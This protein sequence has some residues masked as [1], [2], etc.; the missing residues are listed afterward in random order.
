MRHI[1]AKRNDF[2][3]IPRQRAISKISGGSGNQL[4]SKSAMKSRA[5]QP[6]RLSL[7]DNTQLYNF[8]II[9]VANKCVTAYNQRLANIQHLLEIGNNASTNYQIVAI[10]DQ[11]LTL[12]RCICRILSLDD[13]AIILGRYAHRKLG[14]TS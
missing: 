14:I 9:V 6:Q 11:R 1:V 12:C 8:L 4:A 2:L 3:G 10:K 5:S 7:H 13:I